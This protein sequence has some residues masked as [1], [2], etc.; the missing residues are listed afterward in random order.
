MSLIGA[1]ILLFMM[2]IWRYSKVVNQGA[3]ASSQRWPSGSA[4]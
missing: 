1:L 3:H 2:L 4:K